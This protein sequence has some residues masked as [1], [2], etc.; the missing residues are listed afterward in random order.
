MVHRTPK[1]G[2]PSGR[3][4][5]DEAFDLKRNG[6]DGSFLYGRV[7]FLPRPRRP[8]GRVAGRERIFEGIVDFFFGAE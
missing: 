3:A 4:F 2:V 1:A 5:R 7:G 6:S 8:S